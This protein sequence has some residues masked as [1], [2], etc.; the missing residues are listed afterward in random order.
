MNDARDGPPANMDFSD[1]SRE[2]MALMVVY[3]RAIGATNSIPALSTSVIFLY[4]FLLGLP[5]LGLILFVVGAVDLILIAVRRIFGRP[6]MLVGRGLY[7]R[8]VAAFSSIW[9]GE[10]PAFRIF[11]ARYLTRLY[12]FYRAQSSIS[13]LRRVH[14]R[15][16]R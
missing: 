14:N 1:L 4:F 10:L 15:C 11:R 9:D 16:A 6:K 5:I 13:G 3:S 8:V 12:L 7:A 2:T